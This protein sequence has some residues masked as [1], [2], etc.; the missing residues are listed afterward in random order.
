MVFIGIDFFFS[1]NILL[2]FDKGGFFMPKWKQQIARILTVIVLSLS[3]APTLSALPY[4]ETAIMVQAA[5]RK[6][7]IKQVQKQ[8]IKLGYD[9]GT[10]DGV[11]GKKTKSAIKQFQKDYDLKETGTINQSVLELLDINAT[12]AAKATTTSKSNSSNTK[13][14]NKPSSS[15]SNT[16]ISSQNKQDTT[17]YITD[18]GEKYHRSSCRYLSKSKIPISLSEAKKSYDP[19]SV[20]KP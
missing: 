5:Y 10:A 2:S 3:L 13:S 14:D 1:I 20:C 8:L 6:D 7:I 19:C 12:P 4:G 11:V 17:V 18:T 16:T 15:V 9:C